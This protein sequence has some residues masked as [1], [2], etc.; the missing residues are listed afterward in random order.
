ML[1]SLIRDLMLPEK[2]SAARRRQS[3]PGKREWVL[4]H[5]K[6]LVQVSFRIWGEASQHKSHSE[7]AIA[8]SKFPWISAIS[9]C[10]IGESS[11]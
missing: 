10:T 6:S 3:E 5:R 1:R 2:R 11:R 4:A 8:Y 9:D 7:S